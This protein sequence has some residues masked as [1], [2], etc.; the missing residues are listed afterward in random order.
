MYML[1]LHST[2]SGNDKH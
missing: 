1:V 2:K